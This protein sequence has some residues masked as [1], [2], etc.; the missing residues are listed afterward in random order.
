MA[1]VLW[2]KQAAVAA[3]A[4]ASK[5]AG[6]S[7]VRGGAKLR[8]YVPMRLVGGDDGDGGD[9]DETVLVPVALLNEPRMVGL[10]EMAERQYGYGQPGVLRIPCDARRF[11]QLMGLACMA[12]R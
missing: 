1:K 7:P 9:E 6:S 10:L 12:S 4:A 5:Q 3:A 2:R 11:E 8:G